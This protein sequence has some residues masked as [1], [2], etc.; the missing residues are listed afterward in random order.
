MRL[1]DLDERLRQLRHGEK[2]TPEWTVQYLLLLLPAL[3]VASIFTAAVGGLLEACTSLPYPWDGVILTVL[4]TGL[5]LTLFGLNPLAL[6]RTIQFSQSSFRHTGWWCRARSM[7]YSRICALR[8]GSAHPV[9]PGDQA[10]NLLYAT[11][12]R[13]DSLRWVNLHSSGGGWTVKFAKAVRDE[14]IERCGL[15]RLQQS[16]GEPSETAETFWIRPGS[17]RDDL[18]PLPR[19][20]G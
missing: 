16:D 4:I 6:T 5:V 20:M 14:I 18:P 10:L 1:I 2:V 8:W 15:V 17:S 11:D 12:D 3:V 13:G 7:P 19:W 9:Y